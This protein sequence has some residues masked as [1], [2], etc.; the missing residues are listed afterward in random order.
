MMTKSQKE[1]QRANRKKKQQAIAIAKAIEKTKY[2]SD[3]NAFNNKDFTPINAI[4]LSQARATEKRP[5][6][7]ADVTLLM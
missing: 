7:T 1:R 2:M 5:S 6:Q 4:R 3:R